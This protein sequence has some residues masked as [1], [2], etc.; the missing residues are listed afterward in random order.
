MSQEF[1]F[2]DKES[3]ES[4]ILAILQHKVRMIYAKSISKH[5]FRIDKGPKD[6]RWIYPKMI[7]HGI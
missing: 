3:N 1:L 5:S 4:E 2:K 7:L 6:I